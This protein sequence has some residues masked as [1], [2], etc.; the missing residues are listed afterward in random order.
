MAI[1]SPVLSIRAKCIDCCCGQRKEVAVCDLVECPLFPYRF[2]KNPNRK[3]KGG[4]KP[5]AV[6][7]TQ[8]AI[9]QIKDL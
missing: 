7:P 3:G 4:R 6:S 5:A 8:E 1:L 9:Q 2:G